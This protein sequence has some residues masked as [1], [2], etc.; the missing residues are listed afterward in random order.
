MRDLFLNMYEQI[1]SGQSIVLINIIASTGSTP[2]G[3]GAKMLV[4]ADGKSFGT[5]GGG[6]VEYK[7]QQLAQQVFVNKQSYT[8]HFTLSANQAADL[9]MICGG[10]VTVYFQ[11]FEGGNEKIVELIHRIVE[12]FDRNINSWIITDITDE[13]EWGLAVY[14]Q[15]KSIFGFESI[16]EEDILPLLDSKSVWSE[17]NGKRYYIE[18]LVHSGCVYIF[19]GGHVAQEL[20]P[21]LSH[22]GF[23]CRVLEDRP[24]FTGEKIFPQAESTYLG[25]FGNIGVSLQIG[26]NDYVIIMTRGHQNDYT[27]LA[28]ALR[29][30][31]YYIG[32]IGSKTKV[33]G[34]F[35]KLI[36]EGFTKDDLCRI[37]TPIGLNIKAESPAEIAISI[38]AQLIEVR[39]DNN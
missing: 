10:D 17:K 28:Q 13:R 25:D 4:L 11:Y 20:V 19:G 26:P 5:I 30:N 15:G 36:D 1:Y 27:V 12:L 29:T 21:V 9:G 3:A 34:T 24:E 14:V 23:R 39:A 6:A 32:M 38:A 2:R 16:K 33:A 8:K 22:I 7:C 35:Q 31:A 18:P 37:Y